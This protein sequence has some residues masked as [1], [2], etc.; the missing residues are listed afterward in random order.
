[1]CQD[2]PISFIL[3]NYWNNWN[4]EEKY[5]YKEKKAVINRHVS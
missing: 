4:M 3:N 2:F 5:I 1:M